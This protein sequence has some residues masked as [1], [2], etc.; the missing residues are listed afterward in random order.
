MPVPVWKYVI[1]PHLL[2]NLTIYRA[3]VLLLQLVSPLIS[4]LDKNSSQVVYPF[5]SLFGCPGF[6]IQGAAIGSN[7]KA[8]GIEVRRHFVTL[9]NYGAD[10]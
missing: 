1:V 10:T 6:K 4:P 3:P 7:G 2:N 9:H 8:K 5:S